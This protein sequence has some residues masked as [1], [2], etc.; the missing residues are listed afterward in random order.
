MAALLITILLTRIMP[1]R[2][3]KLPL[4]Q[5]GGKI[6]WTTI[7]PQFLLPGKM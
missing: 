3:Y 5:F 1:T 6:N 7:I 2:T 4:W